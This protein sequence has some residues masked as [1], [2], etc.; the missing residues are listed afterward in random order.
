MPI[1]REIY[2]HKQVTSRNRLGYQSTPNHHGG[3]PSASQ[4]L[5]ELDLDEE[6]DAFDLADDRGLAD[7]DGT[8]YGV[9]P[10]GDGL[11]TIGVWNEQ[12]AEFPVARAGEKWHG[13]PVYPLTDAGPPKRRGQAGRPETAVL[14][15]MH[16]TRVI[17][18]PALKRLMKGD[19]V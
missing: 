13:Y 8:L 18:K 14:N 9:L 10:D 19:H 5:P 11:R 6:F 17:T 15:A 1:L 16:A 2:V 12:V 3:D 7:S 4:W